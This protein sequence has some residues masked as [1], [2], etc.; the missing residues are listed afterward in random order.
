VGRVAAA[1]RIPMTGV[2]IHVPG[3]AV[4]LLPVTALVAA[5]A[6]TLTACTSSG[7]TTTDAPTASASAAPA[8]AADS[9][10]PCADGQPAVA[11]IDPRGTSLDPGKLS[12]PTIT[13]I[14]KN[15]TLRV[16]ISGDVLLWG[17]RNP[18]NGQLEGFDVD[19]AKAIAKALNVGIT[20]KVINYGERLPDLKNG[21]VDIV[22]DQMTI[23]CARWEGAGTASAPNAINFSTDYY[24]AGQKVLVRYDPNPKHTAP[25]PS[26]IEDLAKMVKA[27]P[28]APGMK[29]CV[30]AASTSSVTVSQYIPDPKNQLVVSDLGDCLVKFEEGEA[31]AVTGDDTVLAGF[32][33]QDPYSR[34]VGNAAGKAFT[35]EPY[36]V[37]IQ[38]GDTAFTQFVNA[39][40]EQMRTDGDLKDIYDSTMGTVLK[41][42]TFKVPAPTYK[43]NT[44]ALKQAG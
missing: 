39:V 32:A 43:R 3:R 2:R 34:V 14:R 18:K 44:A 6:I 42:S 22:T 25:E 29:V 8:A 13:A 7:G 35:S 19:V 30:A 17:A 4:R 28:D 36:G 37:G 9:T 20:Y 41:G 21:L 31:T 16:G 10:K 12:G 38:A 27:D 11:S 24:D 1:G 5:A 26:S 40:L 23:N 15:K 33:A